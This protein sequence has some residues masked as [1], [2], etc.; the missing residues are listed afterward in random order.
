LQIDWKLRVDDVIYSGFA[1]TD[2]LYQRPDLSQRRR[3]EE[4]MD[5]LGVASLRHRDVQELSTGELRRVLIARALVGR[6]QV[7]LLDEVCDGLD[8]PARR[9]LLGNLDR[10]VR[11]GTQVLYATHRP[12]EL[13]PSLTHAL[14]LEGGGIV[15]Q[16]EITK[17][18]SPV[19]R[20][21]PCLPNFT[22]ISK[23]ERPR[24]PALH[25]NS[26]PSGVLFRLRGVNVYLNR[27][28][29]L[30]NLDWEMRA[31]ENWAVLGANGAGKSTFLKLLA[32]KLHGAIGSRVQRFGLTPR[33]TFREL[34]KR[35]GYLSP[36]LQALYRDSVTGAEVVASGF[37]SSIGLV[38]RVSSR[39]RRRVENLLAEF[40]LS[41]LA[42]R[43]AMRMSY[44]ELRKL[45]MLRALVH[46]PAVLICDEPFDGL[47][48]SSRGEFCA[49]LDQV[50]RNGTRL[51][52]VTHHL[53]DLPRSIT[54][55]LVLEKGR[56][57]CQGELH[58]VRKH[59]AVER[60]FGT[61]LSQAGQ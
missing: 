6:P 46:E 37:F 39:Q 15:W 25:S 36:V 4:I 23:A 35:V 51:V 54:H 53:S 44:G 7:L 12:D 1:G 5:S 14:M 27:N 29:V 24:L 33:D 2:Y 26:C 59:A 18:A 3:A 38:D 31:G 41:E 22:T 52:T 49:A 21:Q 50:A 32:G 48:A 11:T 55:A 8:A 58:T 60:L 56:M 20:G 57:V 16:G 61:D 45:L 30:R 42:I 28:R 34:R 10:I 13:I 43:P 40:R 9:N 47:D 19:E 17:V